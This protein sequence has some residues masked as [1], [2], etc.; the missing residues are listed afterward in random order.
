MFS[1]HDLA[2][3]EVMFRRNLLLLRHQ[4][5]ELRRRRV[6]QRAI[7]GL[8]RRIWPWF[9]VEEVHLVMAGFL[10]AFRDGLMPLS[11]MWICPRSSKSLMASVATPA[12][13]IGLH[14]DKSVMM[15]SHTDEL[16]GDFSRNVKDVLGMEEYRDIFPNIAIRM[17]IHAAG[18]WRTIHGGGMSA[19]GVGTG[20]AG[21]G[22]NRGEIDDPLNEKTATR[23]TEV[24]RINNWYPMGFYSRRDPMD[25]AINLTQTRWRKDDLSGYLIGVA[26]T[27]RLAD[28][29]QI[30]RIPAIIDEATAELLSE[31]AG[32]AL[33]SPRPDGSRTPYRFKV[34]DS[35]APRRFPLSQLLRIKANQPK[36]ESLYQQH[37]TELE[38]AIYKRK[39]WRKW[40]EPKPPVCF[41]VVQ[42]YDTNFEEAEENDWC[43]RTTWGLFEWDGDGVPRVCAI[44]LEAWRERPSFHDLM[45]YA[46]SM[47]GE[48]DADLL[49]IERKASGHAMLQ[50]CRR[51]AIRS[52]AFKPLTKSKTARAKAA[53]IVLENGNVFYMDRAWATPV[54][55]ECTDFPTGEYDDWADTFTMMCLYLRVNYLQS[56]Q[57]AEQERETEALQKHF[58]PAQLA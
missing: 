30:L 57:E 17:D 51:R 6:E 28:Q 44:L 15:C 1:V 26:K 2:T 56:T 49:V 11:M 35:F 37:P 33:L 53:S 13:Y 8:I 52:L 39:C 55:D 25:S 7:I 21:K 16:A 38:G 41:L 3:S 48:F 47:Y 24:T 58:E 12:D 40:H 22:F 23:D 14:P 34:G 9:I 20:I 5:S 27:D 43:A 54:I 36:F 10:E 50:E 32:H 45:E 31:Q 29:P 46:E 19:A 42:F 18:R 4:R